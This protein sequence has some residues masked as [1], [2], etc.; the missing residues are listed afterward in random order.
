[1]YFDVAVFAVSGRIYSEAENN[2]LKSFRINVNIVVII[3][4]QCDKI[5]NAT[6]EHRM[7]I[8]NTSF[9]LLRLAVPLSLKNRA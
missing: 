3:E 8:S 4:K 5:K 6:I 9:S 7:K 1:M 2:Y